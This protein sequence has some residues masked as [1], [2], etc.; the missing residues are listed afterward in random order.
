MVA[1]TLT[2]TF[3]RSPTFLSSNSSQAAISI[4]PSECSLMNNGISIRFLSTVLPRQTGLS[5][6]RHLQKDI[7]GSL[8]IL[9]GTKLTE[10]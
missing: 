1:E 5:L 9:S 4:T 3:S 8:E 7:A 6:P 2:P 10:K